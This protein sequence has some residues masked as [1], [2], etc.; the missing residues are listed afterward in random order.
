MTFIMA[1]CHYYANINIVDVALYFNSESGFICNLK[2]KLF[3]I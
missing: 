1:F 2:I 3:V